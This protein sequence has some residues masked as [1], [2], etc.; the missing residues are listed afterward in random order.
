[1]KINVSFF[2]TRLNGKIVNVEPIQ[3]MYT[4]CQ[5]NLKSEYLT[6]EDIMKVYSH[7]DKEFQNICINE[8]RKTGKLFEFDEAKELT[9]ELSQYS[10]KIEHR[11]IE[12]ED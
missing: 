2:I 9:Y 7:M 8:I 12:F 4:E 3:D 1:M 5:L 10:I 6:D 11:E